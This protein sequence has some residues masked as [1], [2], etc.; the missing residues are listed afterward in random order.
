MEE[1]SLRL[2]PNSS[3]WGGHG[4]SG[5]I[6][7][8]VSQPGRALL[9]LQQVWRATASYTGAD[10]C[11]QAIVMLAARGLA[12]LSPANAFGALFTAVGSFQAP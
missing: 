12:F 4:H 10:W 7:R 2:E 8:R 6:A 1:L 11:D 3:G 5:I 9:E